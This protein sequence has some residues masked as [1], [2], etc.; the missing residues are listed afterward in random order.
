[1]AISEVHFLPGRVPTSAEIAAEM[2]DGAVLV[3]GLARITIDLDHNAQRAYAY[4]NEGS[5]DA[6]ESRI[7]YWGRD[8]YEGKAN[9]LECLADEIRE[10]WS[11]TK[12]SA[13]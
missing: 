5:I 8:G 3:Y 4:Q 12:G 6:F 7:Q 11:D 2:A 10:F 9:A 1:M 13:S